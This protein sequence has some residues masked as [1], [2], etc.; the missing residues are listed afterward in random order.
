[1]LLGSGVS[2]GVLVGRKVAVLVGVFDAV[3]VA[4]GISV[5][6]GIGVFDG[7]GEVRLILPSTAQ[8]PSKRRSI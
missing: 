6:V 4:E 2:V 7:V 3:G 1:M 5:L 8:R